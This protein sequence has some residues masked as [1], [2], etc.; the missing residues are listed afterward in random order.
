MP[1]IL[2]AIIRSVF[3]FASLLVLTRLTGKQQLSHL[4][5]YDFVSAITIGG[6]TAEIAGE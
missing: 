3:G 5:F 2:E 6:I 4:T 1:E